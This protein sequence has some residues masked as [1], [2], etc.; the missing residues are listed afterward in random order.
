MSNEHLSCLFEFIKKKIFIQKKCQ[1]HLFMFFL[2]IFHSDVTIDI[3][4]HF[5][6]SE[7]TFFSLLSTNKYHFMIY[8]KE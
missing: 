7:N 4:A 1:I 2:S 6:L 8:E 5:F 3:C